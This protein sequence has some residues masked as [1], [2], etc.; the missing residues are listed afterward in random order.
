M[1]PNGHDDACVCA[2]CFRAPT[3]VKTKKPKPTSD[4]AIDQTVQRW[5]WTRAG[6]K[7]ERN[8]VVDYLLRKAYEHRVQWEKAKPGD[9]C[10]DDN[11]AAELL[12]KLADAFRK[13]KHET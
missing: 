6:E 13:G 11:R 5:R 12:Y 9:K 10:E 8:A 4:D 1:K 2:E 3:G 7:G